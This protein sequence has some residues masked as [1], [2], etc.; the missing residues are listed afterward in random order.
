MARY[1]LKRGLL[2]I[3]VLFGVSIVVFGMVHIAPGGPVRLLLGPLQDEALVAK[4]RQNLG[5][6]QPMY[7]QYW[8]WITKVVQGNLGTSLTI[9]PGTPV[10][11]LI[12]DRLPLTIEL[13]VF[14]QLLAVLIGIPA[15]IIGALRQ[16]KP[17]DHVARIGALA[18]ISIPDFWLGVVLIMVFGVFFQF[19]WATGGWVPLWQDP[20]SNLKHILL[21]TIALGT[22]H[23]AIIQRMTR[24]EM[25]ETINQDYIRTAR[26]MGIKK[27]EIIFKDATRNALIPVVTVIG[28]GFGGLM[29][30]AVLT[31]SVFSL[32]GVGRLL[33]L[34]ISR[35]DYRVIQ[36]LVLFIA[37]VFV[38][39]NLAVDVLY[40][41]LDPRIR[42]EG[43]N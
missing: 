29:N 32:P 39:M 3:P 18:G 36:A 12:A 27:Y 2:A 19:K 1:V 11:K 20:V 6:D 23:A 24:S 41:Y 43:Q 4:I 7:V 14:G 35:R 31:E 21:P 13:A 8:L 5:L 17:T 37:I 38:F 34:A 22:A 25:L 40:A 33:I 28:T 42:Q 9:Q 10:T 16:N 15:G 30:G 26:A